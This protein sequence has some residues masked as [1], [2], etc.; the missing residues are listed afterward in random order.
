MKSLISVCGKPIV[1][2][3][4]WL[5]IAGVY[6]EAWTEGQIIERPE[7]FIAELRSS[8][9][10]ADILTFCQKLPDTQPKYDYYYEWENYAVIPLSTFDNWWE[11]RLPQVTRKNIR[12]ATKRGVVAKRVEL[13]DKMLKEITDIFNETPFR[14][15]KRFTHFGKDFETV[16]KEVSTLLDR[17]IFIGAYYEDKLIGYI[18]LVLMG[19]IISI[20]NIITMIEHYDKRPANALISQAVEVSIGIGASFL[21]YGKYSYGNKTK[22]SLAEFKHRNGFE[23]IN[24]PRYYVPFTAKGKIALKMRIHR[25]LFGLLP[26]PMINFLVDLRT[27]LYQSRLKSQGK[28]EIRIARDGDKKESGA[29]SPGGLS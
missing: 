23:Q 27:R 13:N 5:K 28:K 1:I 18:K 8:H 14:E 22:S 26:S 19:P 10:G 9:A 21:V 6:D 24:F 17:S 20:L 12:R 2:R 7:E 16:K 15:G 4:K 3:G 11:N 25:G 29:D